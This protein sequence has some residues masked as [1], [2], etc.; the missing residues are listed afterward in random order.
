VLPYTWLGRHGCD[1]LNTS[2]IMVSP[3]QMTGP[4]WS[5][6]GLPISTRLGSHFISLSDVGR[7][8]CPH[9]QCIGP[10]WHYPSQMT[11]DSGLIMGLLIYTARPQWHHHC[12]TCLR[13]WPMLSVH[14]GPPIADGPTIVSA[15]DLWTSD[16]GV[17]SPSVILRT[18][19]STEVCD[20]SLKLP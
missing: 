14:L 15:N 20:S 2:P 10:S 5:M 6:M 17:L 13:C 19:L 3:S 9:L 4:Q 18:D 7:H 12:L 16:H 1:H 8:F 11:A